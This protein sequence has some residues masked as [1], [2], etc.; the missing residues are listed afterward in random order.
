MRPDGPD[1]LI[2]HSESHYSYV[3]AQGHSSDP[4]LPV[5]PLT[6]PYDVIQPTNQIAVFSRLNCFTL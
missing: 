5:L 3:A 4:K 1:T 6:G 2:R